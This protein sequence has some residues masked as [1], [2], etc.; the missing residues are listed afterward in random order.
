MSAEF[1]WRL[2]DVLD[3]SAEPDD[4]LSP[5]VCFDESPY[6]MVSDVRQPLPVAPGP[7]R[8]SD[9]DYRREG[10]CHV[11]M[12][13]EPRQGWRPVK[14]THRRTIPDFAH[15]LRALVDSPF[16]KAAVISVV[17]ANLHTHTPGALSAT[18][19][20]AEACR[21]LRTLDFHDPPK[22]GGWLNMAAIEVAVVLGQCLDRRVGDQETV[23]RTI[24]A[25]EA[26]A[27]C[28]R[29]LSIGALPRRRRDA[30]SDPS[31]LYN[32]CGQPLAFE[33]WPAILVWLPSRGR[34]IA[35]CASRGPGYPIRLA[36]RKCSSSF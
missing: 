15:G 13:F 8:R 16:P 32:Q 11:L 7:P 18:F 35:G 30:N 4:P 5:L 1:G 26:H 23:C 33:A 17:L 31:T 2:A 10:T 27:R 28:K 3:L 9:D 29:P 6:H 12:F 36:Q 14:V 25:W 21:N 19:P 34:L 24:T 22:P 20:P